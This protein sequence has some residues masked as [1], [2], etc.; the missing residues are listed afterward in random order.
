M[1]RYNTGLGAATSQAL[2]RY[3]NPLSMFAENFLDRLPGGG[4]GG[5]TA[6]GDVTYSSIANNTTATTGGLGDG[7]TQ[8]SRIDE[9]SSAATLAA[10]AGGQMNL[11]ST[12]TSHGGGGGGISS[13]SH[14]VG[15]IQ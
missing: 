10:V 14:Q 15:I 7:S 1:G 12:G 4:G 6:V 8:L 2:R 3:N 11:C 9:S 5:S 13:C